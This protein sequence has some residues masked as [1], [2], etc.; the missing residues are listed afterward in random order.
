MTYNAPAQI[1]MADKPCKT[2]PEVL[3][4][5]QKLQDQ[6]VCIQ[7]NLKFFIKKYTIGKIGFSKFR[8]CQE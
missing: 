3:S 6:R 5:L 7:K 1:E 8:E 2:I 4:Q